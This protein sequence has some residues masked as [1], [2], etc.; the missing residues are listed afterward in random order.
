[1]SDDNDITIELQTELI[2]Y[3]ASGLDDI[4]KL[5]DS[6][7]DK[8]DIP[9]SDSFNYLFDDIKIKINKFDSEIKEINQRLDNIFAKVVNQENKGDLNTN[10]MNVNREILQ[11]YLTKE[12]FD[13]YIKP[14][15]ID[16]QKTKKELQKISEN[17]SQLMI[18]II[19]CEKFFQRKNR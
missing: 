18:T 10:E 16:Y 11:A 8:A 4:A 9:D 17:V 19:Q 5:K 2:P 12:E 15:D 3:F 14:R 7:A 13:S 1:M 6:K